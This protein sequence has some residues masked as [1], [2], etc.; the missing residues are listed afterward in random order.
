MDRRDVLRAAAVERP[1]PHPVPMHAVQYRVVERT[2]DHGM[3][4]NV[5]VE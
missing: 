1:F 5:L 4:L 3:M 2:E